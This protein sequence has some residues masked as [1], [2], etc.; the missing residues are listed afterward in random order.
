MRKSLSF[1]YRSLEAVKPVSKNAVWMLGGVA[2][3]AV[4][5][6]SAQ[7]ASALVTPAVP[8]DLT[9]AMNTVLNDKI[10]MIGLTSPDPAKYYTVG[11]ADSCL[12]DFA[13]ANLDLSRLIPDPMGILSDALVSGVNKI[14]NAAVS[15]AC[16]AA[17]KSFGSTID[18]YNSA[19][20]LVTGDTNAT[21]N[22]AIGAEV[23]KSMT[24]YGLDYN[25]PKVNIN[26]PIGNVSVKPPTVT[27]PNMNSNTTFN[28]ATGVSGN[29]TAAKSST[30]P[31]APATVG[32]SIWGN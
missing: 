3:S 22:K 31:V 4:V 17:R 11:G 8:C 19:V 2:I 25:A 10:R 32:S 7:Q 18:K 20:G 30:A 12:G 1:F 29:A 9:T 21:I 16:K 23:E 15:T 26:D 5:A 28:T 14:A 27:L 13:V 24:D 6:V